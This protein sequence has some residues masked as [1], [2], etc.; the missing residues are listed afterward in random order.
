MMPWLTLF[1]L[2]FLSLL[3]LLESLKKRNPFR[4]YDLRVFVESLLLSN[5]L[6]HAMKGGDQSFLLAGLRSAR[7]FGLS[8]RESLMAL[9]LALL[10]AEE[11]AAS[12]AQLR[13]LF[14]ARVIMLTLLAGIGRA[15][16]DYSFQTRFE[17]D[18]Y[19]DFTALL[20]S[21]GL[22]ALF[23]QLLTRT[24]PRHWIGCEVLSEKAKSWFLQHLLLR[25]DFQDDKYRILFE[26]LRKQELKSGVSSFQAK[27]GILA[28]FVDAQENTYRMAQK[29]FADRLI[30]FEFFGLALPLLL[31]TLVPMLSF[32]QERMTFPH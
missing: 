13:S 25:G 17:W 27:R 30:F 11:E 15:I 29:R 1:G 20:A 2:Y 9:R 5:E 21:L 23:V 19:I 14:A 16:F 22:I 26:D 10:G 3:V 32:Y 18:L 12:I 28:L 7:R 6:P 31:F 8:R 4:L 24:H